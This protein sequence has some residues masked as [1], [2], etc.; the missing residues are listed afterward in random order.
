M[1]SCRSYSSLV[2]LRGLMADHGW[3]ARLGF[4]LDHPTGK[5]GSSAT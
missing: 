2:S 1:I 5:P 4:P 3:I